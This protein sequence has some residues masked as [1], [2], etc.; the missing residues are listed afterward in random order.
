VSVNDTWTSLH[1]TKSAGGGDA[2]GGSGSG[3]WQGMV[4]TGDICPAKLNLFVRFDPT[5]DKY[6]PLMEYVVKETTLT[7]EVRTLFKYL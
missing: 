7:D 4:Y 2:G 3:V 1:Q 5:K 6:V